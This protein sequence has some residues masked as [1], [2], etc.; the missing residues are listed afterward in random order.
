M[1]YAFVRSCGGCGSAHGQHHCGAAGQWKRT[2]YEQYPGSSLLIKITPGYYNSTIAL[3]EF[4]AR[5]QSQP[6]DPVPGPGA[7]DQV[8]P[9]VACDSAALTSP[10]A[11]M[12]P[13][14]AND[15]PLVPFIQAAINSGR[16]LE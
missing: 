12:M 16:W 11:L 2:T 1:Y 9:V 10:P 7:N 14:H 13:Q 5:A 6:S 15:S 8:H 4:I 3:G